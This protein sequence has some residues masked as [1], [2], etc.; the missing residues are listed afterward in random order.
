M[1]NGRH[2]GRGRKGPVEFCVRWA[3]PDYA[4]R[5]QLGKDPVTRPFSSF[6]NVKK[7]D[8]KPPTTDA[9]ISLP[10]LGDH[11]LS[12]LFSRAVREGGL[13]G[14]LGRAAP[15]LEGHNLRVS[16]ERCPHRVADTRS[17][18]SE[19][20]GT[21]CPC[22]CHPTLPGTRW[23]RPTSPPHKTQAWLWQAQGRGSGQNGLNARVFQDRCLE[24]R[25]P[26]GWA[27]NKK[28]M[29]EKDVK[30]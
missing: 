29:S 28:L 4:R 12:P 21:G 18:C 9:F 30:H 5:A 11:F 17:G 23:E 2:C 16:V 15:T 27:P 14:G 19:H 1:N 6:P 3:L 13:A 7:K 22:S 8:R 10:E 24:K 26:L 25:L 20:T